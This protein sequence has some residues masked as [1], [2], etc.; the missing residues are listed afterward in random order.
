[1]LVTLV[2]IFHSVIKDF[3][4]FFLF[5]YFHN[6]LIYKNKLYK[7]LLIDNLDI[8]KMRK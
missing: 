8:K 2:V 1:M 7:I 6:L 5:R 3:V 4:F